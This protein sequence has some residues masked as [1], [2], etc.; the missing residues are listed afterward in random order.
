V[1]GQFG[2][3]HLGEVAVGI[4]QQ[5]HG[6]DAERRSGLPQFASPLPDQVG[7]GLVQRGRLTAGVAQDV[8][9]SPGRHHLVDDRA[10][11]ERLIVGMGDDC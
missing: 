6:G 1:C 11:P 4:I 5:R 8:H 10:E 3:Q 9:R 2:A 7:A